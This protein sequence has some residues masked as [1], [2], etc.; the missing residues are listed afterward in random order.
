MSIPF[1][2]I[3]NFSSRDPA[4]LDELHFLQGKN[5]QTRGFWYPISSEEGVLNPQPN[6]KGCCLKSNEMARHSLIIKG[7][8]NTFPPQQAITVRGNFSI[9]TFPQNTDNYIKLYT[10]ENAQLVPSNS[11]IDSIPISP[12]FGILLL[13]V[14]F[15]F[16]ILKKN[17]QH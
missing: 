6:F 10:L 13:I 17:Q 11:F 1:I 16:L 2:K 4:V 12:S 5:I 9:S 7:A 15:L 3:E 14:F 8:V